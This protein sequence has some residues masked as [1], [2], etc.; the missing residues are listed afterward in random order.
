MKLK[1]PTRPLYKIAGIFVLCIFSFGA[2]YVIK[3][4]DKSSDE[5]LMD[6]A[7]YQI[8]DNSLFSQ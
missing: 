6:A 2:G 3:G 8:S 5:G 4:M 7:Y 1:N